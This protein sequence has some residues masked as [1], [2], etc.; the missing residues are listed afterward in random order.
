MA[1]VTRGEVSSLE[2]VGQSMGISRRAHERVDV[3]VEV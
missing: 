1:R 3:G 2:G